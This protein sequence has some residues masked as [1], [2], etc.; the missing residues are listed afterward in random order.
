MEQ[1]VNKLIRLTK[2]QLVM[3]LSCLKHYKDIFD[4]NLGEWTEKQVDIPLEKNSEPHH[5]QNFPDS[6]L[7]FIILIIDPF[8]NGWSKIFYV[9][10]VYTI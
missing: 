8:I 7:K 6:N 2:F 5:E 1:E 4:G 3:L 9:I 10:F